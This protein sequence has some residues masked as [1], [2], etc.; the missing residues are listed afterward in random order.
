MRVP[1]HIRILALLL[2]SA[3]SPPSAPADPDTDY[4]AG[5]KAYQTGD[6]V[7]A[8]ESLKQAA[9]AGHAPAQTLLADVL[10]KSDFNEEALTWYRKAAAQGNADAEYG[11]GA[12]HAAG[13]G[14]ARNPAEARRW[15][16]LAAARGHTQSIR[17]L[18][19]AYLNGDLELDEAARQ[20][21][22]AL[23][24]VRAA[25]DKDYLPAL[26][27]MAEA[28]GR[29][30]WGLIPDSGKAEQYRKRAVL[31]RGLAASGNKK[32]RRP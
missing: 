3:A 27:A 23:A 5:F 16:A 8:M 4:R 17:V 30:R 6:M 20:G 22:D 9:E 26:D 28:Y 32:G 18:A 10:D 24:A 14:V 31:L 11:L 21:P 25:A 7:T 13:E 15:F 29:G 2:A 19:H 1:R 12:M